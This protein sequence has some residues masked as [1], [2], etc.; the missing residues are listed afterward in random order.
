MELKDLEIYKLSRKLSAEAWKIF[1]KMDYET[2]KIIGYQ[3]ITSIDS[4]GANIA[5][6]FGRFHYLDKNKFNLNARG[7][8][9]EAI[10]WTELLGER[11]KISDSDVKHLSSIIN[12]LHPKLNKYISTTR[13]LS[14]K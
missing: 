12:E 6:G 7:S 2:K 9:L 5:E 1:E 4:V 10:H 13:D 3:W 8:L 14:K 11:K